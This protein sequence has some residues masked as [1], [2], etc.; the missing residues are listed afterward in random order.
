M[1]NDFGHWLA[2]FIAGEGCFRV[3]K[4]KAGGYYACH[5]ALKLRDDE[6]PILSEIV[7]TTGIG[8][9]KADA[10][11]RGN[12]QPCAVWVV[13]SKAECLRLVTLLDPLPLRARK[14]KDYAIWREAV[15][16]WATMPRGNRWHGPRDWSQM[17]AYKE[18]IEQ[19]R[20]YP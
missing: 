2:G 19:A 3:H 13:Q 7:S 14:A 8:H 18:Q 5:F 10:A 20:A 12:S 15:S 9:I 6:R 1:D 11:G 4:E 16:Y 17:I